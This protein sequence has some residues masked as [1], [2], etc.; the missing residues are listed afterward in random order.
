MGSCGGS[1]AQALALGRRRGGRRGR[2]LVAAIAAARD[3]IHVSH[4]YHNVSPVRD[5]I[6]VSRVYHDVYHSFGR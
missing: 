2:W 6:L 4:V 3:V 1:A 5:V